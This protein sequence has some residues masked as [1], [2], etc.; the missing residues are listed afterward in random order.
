MKYFSLAL[1]GAGLFTAFI[2]SG[3]QTAATTSPLRVAIAGMVHG[4]VEGF[5]QHSLHRPDIQIVGFAEPDTQVA[6]ALRGAVQS[7]PQ[8]DLCRSGRHAAEDPP[9]GCP[10]VH[11]HLRSPKSRGNMRPPRRPRDDGKAAGSQRR[12]CARHRRR[13][14]PGQDP[15]AG[16]LRD[17]LVSQQSCGL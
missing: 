1:L 3:A 10:G 12:R 4:H 17:L 2:A 16:E 14:A 5:L 6:D 11:Q 8:S 7:R 15:G 9:A 13:R